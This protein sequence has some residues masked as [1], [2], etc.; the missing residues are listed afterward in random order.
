MA[1]W[2]T[3]VERDI[4]RTVACTTEEGCTKATV[5]KSTSVD[6][7]IYIFTMQSLME[8]E[9]ME[10]ISHIDFT[11][12]YRNYQYGVYEFTFKSVFAAISI[13]CATVFIYKS[14]TTIYEQKWIAAL[15]V[16]LVM[17]NNPIYFLEYVLPRDVIGWVDAIFQ[18]TFVSMLMLYWLVTFDG[19]RQDQDR[20]LLS[21]S[22]LSTC[23]SSS[24]LVWCT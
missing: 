18:A 1:E 6:Y 12:V 20:T 16:S 4:S 13:I 8:A 11:F 5:F 24:S 19:L 14:K 2:E 10:W 9:D 17:Y 3:I 7:S 15:F 23:P 21:R 22:S